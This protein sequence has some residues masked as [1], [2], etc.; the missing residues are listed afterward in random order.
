[1]SRR[2]ITRI[3]LGSVAAAS[4]MGMLAACA[5]GAG[6][7]DD[8]D[9]TSSAVAPPTDTSQAA[10]G[11]TLTLSSSQDPLCLDGHQVSSAALQML[12]RIVY[13]NLVSLDENG[14]PSPWLAESWDVSDDGTVYTFHLREGVTFS[15]GAPLNAA[16]VVA[17]FDHMR[18][19]A[20]KSPLA[21]AYIDPIA[22]TEI[23]DDLTLEVSLEYS[24]SPFLN[25]LAQSWLGLLSP[26]Q[27]AESP[28]ETCLD[29]IGSGPFVVDAYTPGEGVTFDRREDYDWSADYLNHD[30]AAYID[31]I[32]ISFVAE[33]SVR[34]TSLAS[35]EFDGTD[36]VAPQ[37]AASVKAD[38]SID[39][40]NISR[41]GNPQRITLNTS[42]APFDDVDVRRA[43]AEGIDV[44]GIV[45]A[46]GF[47]EYDV[48]HAYLSP[49][50]Q[51]YNA[52]AESEWVHDPEHAAEL[53][54]DAGWSERDADGY[55]TKNGERLHAEFPI[56]DSATATALNDLI[57][58]QFKDLGIE[59]E[60]I[61]LPQA[62]TSER[63]RA[64][65]FDV[66]TGVWHTNTP[67]AL[68]VVYSSDEITDD[69]RIG[70]NTSRITD[71]DL[72]QALLKA[73]QT[74]DTTE[75]AQLY[76]HAQERLAELVPAIPLYDFYT[77]WAVREN[78]HDALADSSHGVPLFTIAW[79]D[80]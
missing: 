54:D 36:N 13:D 35:G 27:I 48:R 78:V 37:N 34:F 8:R 57:Q 10:Q 31:R 2:P 71:E 66:T 73:R 25:V 45:G 24:Y 47:G 32:E 14:D 29:P 49:T 67:D 53:L 75:L 61:Q 44:E 21:A 39:Y 56:V 52:D 68:Y 51:Y 70:Q 79:L 28:D 17:N 80:Q 30:G 60:L 11:G 19:P 15:D 58:S 18:D 59:V 20:T 4:M 46:V 74:T 63:V 38:E 41:L 65:D 12:G 43:V 55:R 76:A 26:E 50:T 42:R 77:P 1:M 3:L 64:G 16:A 7:A 23:I 33:P 72:D 62:E 40:F 22:S 5:S 6:P 9:T 69:A